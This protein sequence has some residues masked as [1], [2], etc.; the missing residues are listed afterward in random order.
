MGNDMLARVAGTPR[1]GSAGLTSPTSDTAPR[2]P[3]SS[4]GAQSGRVVTIDPALTGNAL[5]IVR[6]IIPERKAELASLLTRMGTHIETT[7]EMDF[8]RLT[9]VHFL[10]WVV[11]EG[12][13]PSDP[14][15]LV[16]E[17]NYDGTLEQH[18]DD[19]YLNGARC[20]HEVYRCCEG[21]PIAAGGSL[22]EAEH[23]RAKEFLKQGQLRYEA[24]Y[25]G[26]RGKSVRRI[27]AESAL[28]D[29][30]QRF[31]DGLGSE[32]MRHFQNDPDTAYTAI[33]QH[34]KTHHLASFEQLLAPAPPRPEQRI[35]PI[36][37]RAAAVLPPLAALLPVLYPLLRY[38]EETDQAESFDA[39]PEQTQELVQ[40]EDFQVQN[41][42]THLVAVKPG[43]FR[44]LT[45][46][47][48]FYAIET[49]A[50]FYFNQGNLG[51]LSTIH[52]ARWVLLDGGRRLL[53]FSNYDGSWERY[54]GDFIDQAHVGLTAV[55][56]NTE[57]FPKTSNLAF[58]GA[59][60]EERFKAWTRAH[61]LPTQLWYSAYK[62]LTVPNIEQNGR[63][64]AGLIQKPGSRR[65]LEQWLTL[66]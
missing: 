20:L 1:F 12:L 49:L 53:F 28:R 50:R 22:D 40:R 34:L 56:S 36:V 47:L 57:G 35:A 21:Y 16:F 25:V 55:W 51:G 2:E 39:L 19:L 31:L 60:D 64:C 59:T 46:R 30:I 8:A 48:V 26:C 6:R 24:F 37:L 33:V 29:A 61:Q 11:I 3:P 65:A 42:L 43:R 63:I 17:S 10:R 38:K 23:P 4:P 13:T 44:L 15:Q 54:L 66:L 52:Y 5:T 7:A 41:Q 32:P 45:L 9:T 18:L 27:R 58:D 14:A 62:D